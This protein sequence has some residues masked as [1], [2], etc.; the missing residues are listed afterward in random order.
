MKCITSTV[1][2]D[3]GSWYCEECEKLAGPNQNGVSS[4][5]SKS[6]QKIVN[7]K[8]KNVRK[9]KYPSCFIFLIEYYIN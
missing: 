8:I 4:K 3:A 1:P 5:A 6:T 7:N 2:S 9:G